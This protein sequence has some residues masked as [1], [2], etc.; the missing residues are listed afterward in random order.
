MPS[1]AWNTTDKA[2]IKKANPKRISPAY[3]LLKIFF[4]VPNLIFENAS[5]IM[6]I[7]ESNAMMAVQPIRENT[8]PSGV[9]VETLAIKKRKHIPPIK[10]TSTKFLRLCFTVNVNT[11]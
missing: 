5:N 2:T 3:V 1:V 10:N 6:L 11:S 7:N 8:A 9:Q 4:K